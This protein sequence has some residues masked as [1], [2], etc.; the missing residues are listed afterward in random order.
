MRLKF[1]VCSI[2][3]LEKEFELEFSK[4]LSFLK[5][6]LAQGIFDLEYNDCFDPFSEFY[7]IY[8]IHKEL[9]QYCQL[10]NK[11]FKDCTIKELE[12]IIRSNKFYQYL[13]NKINIVVSRAIGLSKYV[14]DKNSN[15]LIKVLN[16]EELCR[17][18]TILVKK[19]KKKNNC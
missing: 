3:Y 15:K 10:N 17:L 8:N 1:N 7:S 13:E 6:L 2:K 4:E 9:D 16:K 12:K 11:T 18:Y 5:Y 19:S 14:N